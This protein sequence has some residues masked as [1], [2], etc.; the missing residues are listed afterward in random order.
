MRALPTS[1]LASAALCAALLVGIAGS[2]A[3]ATDLAG[4]RTRTARHPAVPGAD[5]LLARIKALSDT[6]SVPAPVAEL[7]ERSLREARLTPGEAHRLGE[8]A[9]R[10]VTEAATGTP[11]AAAAPTA[12]AVPAEPPAAVTPTAPAA[13]PTN[14]VA[15]SADASL[16]SAAS[17]SMTATPPA[18]TPSTPVRPPAATPSAATPSTAA[19]AVVPA[20]PALPAVP[21]VPAVPAG[22]ALGTLTQTLGLPAPAPVPPAAGGSARLAAPA[23]PDTASDALAKLTGAIDALVKA[24]VSSL[25]DVLPAATG[26]VNGLLGLLKPVLP[27]AGTPTPAP[28]AALPGLPSV[29]ALPAG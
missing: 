4:E 26:V 1:R 13:T 17:P 11:A 21:A 18:A 3:V 22:S 20:L 14:A 27:G 29:P 8:A 15:P 12:A 9:K 28:S 7:L 16:S 25:D 2:A 19:G 24:V 6:G 5:A 10:A 23:A